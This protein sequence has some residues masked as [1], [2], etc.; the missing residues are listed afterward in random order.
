MKKHF[1]IFFIFTLLS[2][3]SFAQ[4]EFEGDSSYFKVKPESEGKFKLGV[5]LGVQASVLSGSESSNTYP[6]IGI[7]GGTYFRYNFKKRLTLQPALLIGFKGS[8]FNRNEPEYYNSLKL[9]YTELPIQ[10]FY[11][12]QR[13]KQ[14][15]MGLGLYVSEL[16]NGNLSSSGGSFLNNQSTLP[17]NNNDWG[18]LASWQLKFTYFSL[19]TSYKLGLK[20]INTGKSWPQGDNASV[21]KP[22]NSGGS[23]YNQTFSIQLNF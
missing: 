17:I 5:C 1:L 20:N 2:F 12:Y 4:E 23:F 11:T 9:L 16:V 8:K 22:V 10:L 3:F 18:L 21:I 19:Q 6:L 13:Q 7:M 14:N 15:Q